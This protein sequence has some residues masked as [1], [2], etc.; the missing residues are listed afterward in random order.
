MVLI[1]HKEDKTVI[2]RTLKGKKNTALETNI[3]H[4][5]VETVVTTRKSYLHISNYLSQLNVTHAKF[6]LK[7]FGSER[8]KNNSFNKK[9]YGYNLCYHYVVKDGSILRRMG[10]CC[11]T[12]HR[13]NLGHSVSYFKKECVI[14]RLIILM[15][16]WINDSARER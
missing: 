4:W 13:H 8:G 2:Y 7:Y 11:L 3:R 5:I 16:I 10:E 14:I 9:W 6:A 15:E 1:W 12:T